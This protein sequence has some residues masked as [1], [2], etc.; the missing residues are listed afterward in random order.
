MNLERCTHAD[1][2]EIVTDVED[3]C[4]TDRA[5]GRPSPMLVDE[6]AES[7]AFA[8]FDRPAVH[9]NAGKQ[10]QGDSPRGGARC[11]DPRERVLGET[12]PLLW[13]SSVKTSPRSTSLSCRPIHPPRTAPMSTTIPI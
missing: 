11:R 10:K 4:G 5:P 1:F 13:A 3:F 2:L 7:V 12:P 8:S 9:S 6:I